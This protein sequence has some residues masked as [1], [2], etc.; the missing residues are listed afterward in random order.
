MAAVQRCATSPTDCLEHA[1]NHS[2]ARAIFGGL[3]RRQVDTQAFRL[4]NYGEVT[5]ALHGVAGQRLLCL[6]HDFLEGRVETRGCFSD[7]FAA[8]RGLEPC[9]WQERPSHGLVPHVA[10]AIRALW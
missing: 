9:M 8:A 7:L 6:D 3:Y 1:H 5:E 2:A 10:V 4:C